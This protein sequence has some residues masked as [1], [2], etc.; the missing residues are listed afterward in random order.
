MK[1][2]VKHFQAKYYAQETGNQSSILGRLICWKW[3]VLDCDKTSEKRKVVFGIN[4]I[5]KMFIEINLI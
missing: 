1:L 5:L 2:K 4:F 3:H